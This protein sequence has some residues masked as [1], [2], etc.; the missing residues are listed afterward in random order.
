MSSLFNQMY[1]GTM[2]D[3]S[4]ALE[5]GIELD[6]QLT[7]ALLCNIVRRLDV[8]GKVQGEI[9]QRLDEV[10]EPVLRTYRVTARPQV[11]DWDL[12]DLDGDVE[13]DYLYQAE[14]REGALDQF[15]SIVPI[16]VLDDFDILCD[17]VPAIRPPA[18]CRDCGTI[19]TKADIGQT[20]GECHRGVI[21]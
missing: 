7:G 3:V 19:Y 13:G 4:D 18:E 9:L 8:L 16:K 21:E 6:A 11:E 1:H 10:P 15:H 20:C 2:A 14:D 5:A 17:P 12:N